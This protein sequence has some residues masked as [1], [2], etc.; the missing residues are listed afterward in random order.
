MKLFNFFNKENKEIIKHKQNFTPYIIVADMDEE[1]GKV[2][3][4]A[5][6]VK[7]D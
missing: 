5:V 3:I 4:R 7:N 6:K 1:T 2:S